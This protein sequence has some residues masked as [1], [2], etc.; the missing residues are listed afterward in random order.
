MENEVEIAKNRLVMDSH[1]L[2]M[3][4]ASKSRLKGAE[5]MCRNRRKKFQVLEKLGAHDCCHMSFPK[6]CC[7]GKHA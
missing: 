3:K 4:C 6:S 1:L 2:A 7:A 5:K